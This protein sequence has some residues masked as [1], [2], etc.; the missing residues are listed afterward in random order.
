MV[1]I[2]AEV[3]FTLARKVIRAAS[4]LNAAMREMKG[5]GRSVVRSNEKFKSI[6]I[7]YAIS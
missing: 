5:F 3:R 1:V 7:N 4:V 6:C 2:V